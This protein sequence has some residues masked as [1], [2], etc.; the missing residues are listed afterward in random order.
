M[1]K[2]ETQAAWSSGSMVGPPGQEGFAWATAEAPGIAAEAPEG[3]IA[4]TGGFADGITA[5]GLRP[6]ACNIAAVFSLVGFESE[7]TPA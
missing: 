6:H 2:S 1:E 3:P 5:G 7:S 4:S